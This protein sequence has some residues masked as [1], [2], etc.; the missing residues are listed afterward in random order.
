MKNSE[1]YTISKKE[2]EVLETFW[3]AD[4]PLLASDV[5]LYNRNLKLNTV[6]AVLKQL[7]N[8]GLVKVS[9]I[10]INGTKL[11]R[12]FEPTISSEEYAIGLLNYN[13]RKLNKQTTTAGIVAC[14]LNTDQNEHETII[15]LENLI[16]ERKVEL[17]TKNNK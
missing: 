2:L 17:Y 4:K 10:V 3:R 12:T 16:K 13:F 8:I 7:L 11:G 6:R 1:F 15:E 5:P 9:D 14:L